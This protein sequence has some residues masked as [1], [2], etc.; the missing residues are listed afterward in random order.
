LARFLLFVH[1][2]EKTMTNSSELSLHDHYFILEQR[3]N[4]LKAWHKM[5]RRLMRRVRQNFRLAPI[6]LHPLAQLKH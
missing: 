2:E 4:D 1:K 5:N 6:T 3:L